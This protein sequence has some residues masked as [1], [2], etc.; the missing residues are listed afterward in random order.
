MKKLMN[1]IAAATLM[2]AATVS[3]QALAHAKLQTAMPA[4]GSTGPSP[5]TIMLHF[6]EKMAAKLSSF[7]ITTADGAKIDVTPTVDSSGM[8]M[9]AKPKAPLAPGLYKVNWHAV[10]SDGHRVTGEFTFTV[11]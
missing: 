7:D 2:I 4:A 8:M 3:T 1:L 6:N 5:K 9:T 10:T 11:K